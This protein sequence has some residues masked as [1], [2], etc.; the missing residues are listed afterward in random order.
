VK[1]LKRIDLCSIEYLNELTN[2]LNDYGITDINLAK[3]LKTH[4]D[5]RL[6]TRKQIS[7][8]IEM[9]RELAMKSEVYL[10]VMCT[11]PQIFTMEKR[12]IS[13]RLDDLKEFFTNKQL[14]KVLVNSSNLLTDN[15]VNIRYK[16]SYVYT[17]MG[18]KQ[19]EMSRTFLFNHTIEHIRERHLFLERSLFYDKPNKKGMTKV[20]NPPLYQIIDSN[21]KEFLRICTKNTFSE[22]DYHTFCEYLKGESFENELLAQYIAKSLKREIINNV[23]IERRLVN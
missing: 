20:P 4:E 23:N 22:F 1:T 12:H 6:L 2:N 7:N 5:W 3:M 18:I 19:D 10:P 17:L 8:A 21:L 15:L 11:N 13:I 9:F 16:F 14:D